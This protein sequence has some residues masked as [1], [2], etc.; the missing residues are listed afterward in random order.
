[1][2]PI[3]IYFK[4]KISHVMHWNFNHGCLYI[5]HSEQ[6]NIIHIWTELQK[7]AMDR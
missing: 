7:Q 6:L 5:L 4:M 3:Y 2:L 1:M